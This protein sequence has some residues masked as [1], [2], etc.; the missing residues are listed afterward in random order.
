[1]D[2]DLFSVVSWLTIAFLTV[3][4]LL[5]LFSGNFEI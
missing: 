4:E 1:M 2:D 5:Y 3:H